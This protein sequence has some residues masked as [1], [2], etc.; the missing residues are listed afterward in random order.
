MLVK[1]IFDAATFWLGNTLVY[2]INPSLEQKPDPENLLVW[3]AGNVLIRYHVLDLLKENRVLKTN[4]DIYAAI[5][6]LSIFVNMVTG[7]E[8]DIYTNIKINSVGMLSNILTSRF[9][10]PKQII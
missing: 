4:D 7:L 8:T 1:V 3:T 6:L 10:R 9:V 5:A 2:S